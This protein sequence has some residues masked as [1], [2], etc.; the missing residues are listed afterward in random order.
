MYR[1]NS[2]LNS[3]LDK[4]AGV[5]RQAD[6]MQWL[7]QTVLASL[8]PGGPYERKYLAILLLNTLLEVWN[9]PDTGTKTYT[10]P[11]CGPGGSAALACNAGILVI[12]SHPFQAFCDG[13]FEAPSVHVL[14]GTPCLFTCL[15]SC[16]YSCLSHSLYN[17]MYSCLHSCL[18]SCLQE[19]VL[20]LE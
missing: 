2:S 19:H 6:F 12:G 15:Y 20:L 7:S 9:A 4:L 18:Y 11:S 17:S 1:W 10:P 3:L 5:Q 14:L 8:Y 13:F 16:L